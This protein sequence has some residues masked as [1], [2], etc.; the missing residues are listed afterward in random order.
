MKFFIAS[1]LIL[2]CSIIC[3]EAAPTVIADGPQ[4]IKE[5]IEK[6]QRECQ[7]EAKI[8]TFTLY[9]NMNN[10]SATVDPLY[11]DYLTC[12]YKKL[13]FQGVDGKISYE[14]IIDFFGAYSVGV[15]R[16]HII[17]KCKD[18]VGSSHG[19]IAYNAMK[20]VVDNAFISDNDIDE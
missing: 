6:F 18:T 19:E 2:I 11:M 17:N 20:C 16:S 3:L 4:K 1:C 10:F 9:K 5:R 7:K 12:Y 15:D 14:K 13:G 8:D